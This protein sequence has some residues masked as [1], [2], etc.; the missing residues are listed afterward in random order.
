MHIFIDLGS[1]DGVA[2]EEALKEEEKSRSGLERALNYLQVLL[3]TQ[4]LIN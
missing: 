4:T 3:G 2:V 1:K